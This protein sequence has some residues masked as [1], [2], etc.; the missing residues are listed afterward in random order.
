MLDK[1]KPVQGYV[2]YSEFR[3]GGSTLQ[4]F[5][6]PDGFTTDG[7]FVGMKIHRRVVSSITPKK[8]WKISSAPDREVRKFVVDG[9]P[10][11]FDADFADTRLGFCHSLLNSMMGGSWEMV[12]HPIVVEASKKDMDDL[13]ALKTP[14]K[15]IYRIN[16]TREAAG[17][18]ENLF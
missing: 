18:P 16:Q 13:L 12:K 17:F 14:T 15:I 8:Q 7:R 3:Q 6:T 2:V 10:N 4:M 11:T 1:D 5:F 9:E